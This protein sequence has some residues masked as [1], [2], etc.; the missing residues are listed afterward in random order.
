MTHTHDDFECPI[1][2]DYI[3]IK[4][5]LAYEQNPYSMH[6]V[7]SGSCHRET[8]LGFDILPAITRLQT[9]M[10]IWLL[11]DTTTPRSSELGGCAT[12]AQP[13][14]P[15]VAA[16]SP[17]W[18]SIIIATMTHQH[19]STSTSHY[20]IVA[21]AASSSAWLGSTIASMTQYLH[22]VAVK[23]P[24]HHRQHDLTS[25]YRHRQ[26]DSAASLPAWLDRDITQRLDHQYQ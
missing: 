20:D 12:L 7:R 5:W 13:V 24:R 1:L 18:L 6:W 14:Q 21:L 16:P 11:H 15:W 22:H 4:S 10:N 3:N 19:D 2:R 17:V 26:Y 25:T 9:K 8:P 23:S